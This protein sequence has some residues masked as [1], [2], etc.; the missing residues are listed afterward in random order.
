VG[1][2][3]QSPPIHLI[4]RFKQGPEIRALLPAMIFVLGCFAPNEAVSISKARMD[5]VGFHP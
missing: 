4:N 5:G 2:T 3:D 1:P